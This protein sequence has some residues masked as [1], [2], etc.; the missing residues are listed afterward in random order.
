MSTRFEAWKRE[1]LEVYGAKVGDSMTALHDGFAKARM[2]LE[3]ETEA[4]LVKSRRAGRVR[5]PL[6]ATMCATPK[7]VFDR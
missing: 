3:K 6:V 4:E 1:I 2:A 7:S 5:G